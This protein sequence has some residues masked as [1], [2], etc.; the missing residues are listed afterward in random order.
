MRHRDKNVE[1]AGLRLKITTSNTAGSV[2][3][4]L[5]AR[6]EQRGARFDRRAGWSFLR[7][8]TLWAR[9]AALRFLQCV[10]LGIRHE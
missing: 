3:R 9:N 8:L 6:Y 2:S 5:K 4:S 7:G 1:R 10:C